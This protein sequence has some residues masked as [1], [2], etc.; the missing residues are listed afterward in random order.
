MPG[1]HATSGHPL[2]VE[3]ITLREIRPEVGFEVRNIK[4]SH[5]QTFE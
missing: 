2:H 1:A 4:D 3:R 5:L